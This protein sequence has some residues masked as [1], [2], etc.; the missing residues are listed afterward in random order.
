MPLP[1]PRQRGG[2]RLAGLPEMTRHRL[3]CWGSAGTFFLQLLDDVVTGPDLWIQKMRLRIAGPLLR[4]DQDLGLV[5][6]AHFGVELLG[7]DPLADNCGIADQIE[8]GIALEHIASSVI[9]V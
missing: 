2:L 9:G 8:A 1:A 4:P 5:L 3:L 7:L 6:L